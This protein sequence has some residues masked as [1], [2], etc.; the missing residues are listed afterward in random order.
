MHHLRGR[1][2][3]NM[4]CDR[5]SVVVSLVDKYDL[6]K[7]ST[8]ARYAVHM[9]CPV[10]AAVPEHMRIC[11]HCRCETAL[12]NRQ[13]NAAPHSTPAQ[14]TALSLHSACPE[15]FFTHLPEPADGRAVLAVAI[16]ILRGSLQ[17]RQVD[18]SATTHQLLQFSRPA[19][20][21]TSTAVM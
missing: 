4:A 20:R 2:M 6:R 8:A 3:H 12:R 14:L 10:C 19:R 1:V 16:V 9:H 18:H 11:A 17:R 13:L 5:S 21:K 15:R 7:A